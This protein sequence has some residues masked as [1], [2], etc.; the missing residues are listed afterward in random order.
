MLRKTNLSGELLAGVQ[1]GGH[2]ERL[3]RTEGKMG[4]TRRRM[5]RG[6]WRTWIRE[7]ILVVLCLTNEW[8]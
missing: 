6:K 2:V 4:R 8:E 7:E 1:L 3:K 5:R